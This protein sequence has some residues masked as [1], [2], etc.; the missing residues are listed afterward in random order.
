[1]GA[2]DARPAAPIYVAPGEP[3]DHQERVEM[4]DEERKREGAEEEIEDLEAPAGSQ[5]DVV[6]GAHCIPPSCAKPSNVVVVCSDIAASCK[7][8]TFGCDDGTHVVV[9]HAQ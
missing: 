8:S 1:V 7:A 3:S 2:A 5:G 4:T 9:I 6:G